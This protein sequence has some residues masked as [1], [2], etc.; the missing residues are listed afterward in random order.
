MAITSKNNGKYILLIIGILVIGMV[1]FI[2]LSIKPEG[3]AVDIGHKIIPKPVSYEK[4][5]GNFTL[6]EQ[7]KIYVQGKTEE[8]TNEIV[9]VAQY[10]KEKLSKSTGYPLEITKGNKPENGS[11]FLTTINGEEVQGNEGY[12]INT[13]NE[14]I[15]ITAYK[16][17]GLFR[18]IQTLKQLFPTE[19]EKNTLVDN[20]KWEIECSVIE[21]KPQY[22]YRGFM[23]DVARNF[24]QVNDLKRQID[25]AAQY[26]INKIHLHLSDDQGWRLEIKSW[27]D[28]AKIGGSTSVGGAT[29]G[30]YTQEE[31]KEIVKYAQDRYVEI[32]PEFDMPGHSN[33][34][35][36]SYDFLN[37]D[38]SKKP[39]YTGIE[40]GFS[41]LM[42]KDEK[43][44]QMIEDI[45][46][47][48]S[49]ITPGKYIHIGGD[50]AN[51]TSK[52]DYDYFIGR[53]CKMIEK[54]GKTPI[55][56]DPIESSKE[57]PNSTITQNWKSSSTIA[58]K[59]QMKMIMS[60]AEKAYLDM[61][62]SSTT[63]L[64][65]T[66]AGFSSIEDAYTWDATD[67]GPEN[68]ILGIEAPLFTETISSPESMDY[69]VYP[70][71]LGHAEV[72]WTAKDDREWDEYRVR[73]KAHGER[74]ENMGISYFK[75]ENIFGE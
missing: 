61:K 71:L 28:L 63:P 73:L 68:L 53:V 30:Y 60:K 27:P 50:E 55:G 10:L 25:N 43:T 40:V 18:G 12:K 72:G 24:V 56:W 75:D 57:A 49:E 22:E 34:M 1:A 8:E 45:I 17:Q 20:K 39:L 64:G 51:S 29:S 42:C 74:L 5:N 31:Y 38:G 14:A 26:K 23:I 13:T 32:I 16:P 41:T 37:P 54:Y 7:S 35:L 62:Y 44:F 66:W 6:T 21:D 70:R 59:K 19:I 52:E 58:T 11:I 4:K 65:L 48:V 47:E 69:M 46:R 3:E 15:E 67:Y 33:A 36:A 9:K 2:K